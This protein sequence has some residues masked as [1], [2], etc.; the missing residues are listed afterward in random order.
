[1]NVTVSKKN[2]RFGRKGKVLFP[3]FCGK[4]EGYRVGNAFG[5]QSK[6]FQ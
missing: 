2:L 1:M 3:C 4:V 6:P 5:V